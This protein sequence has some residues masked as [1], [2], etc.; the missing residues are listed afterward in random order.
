MP[1]KGLQAEVVAENSAL[2][3]ATAFA[4]KAETSM[5]AWYKQNFSGHYPFAVVGN[6]C[7]GHTQVGI[8]LLGTAKTAAETWFLYSSGT[9]GMIAV[10]TDKGTTCIN[11]SFAESDEDGDWDDYFGTHELVEIARML[12]PERTCNQKQL[13]DCLV[14]LQPCGKY[15][16]AHAPFPIYPHTIKTAQLIQKATAAMAT[17]D[18]YARHQACMAIKVE[19]DAH[20]SWDM[21]SYPHH[22]S[23]CL[24]DKLVHRAPEGHKNMFKTM[25]AVVHTAAEKYA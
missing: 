24:V 2:E 15:S 18:P 3:W 25:F 16:K 20:F 9:K 13:I 11:T 4:K 6:P 22:P 19:A 5:P 1:R 8:Q 17:K 14:Q 10:I 23:T 21:C 7:F 12:A